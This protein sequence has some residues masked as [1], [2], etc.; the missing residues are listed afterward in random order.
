[1]TFT[2]KQLEDLMANGGSVQTE[3]GD[4]IV[5]E[6]DAPAD[7]GNKA[8]LGIIAQLMQVNREFAQKPPLPLVQPVTPPAPAPMPAPRKPS[9][10][11]CEVQERDKDGRISRFQ[12][13]EWE[14]PQ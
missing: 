5:I 10:F 3:D 8:L 12:I 1:M 14:G 7:S 13:K 11:N 9:C 6:K 4:E 2:D